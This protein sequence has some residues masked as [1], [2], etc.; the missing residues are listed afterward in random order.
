MNRLKLEQKNNMKNQ[1]SRNPVPV[2]SRQ[3][4]TILTGL[5]LAG[6]A[7]AQFPGG[8]GG[9]RTSTASTGA[10]VQQAAQQVTV[11]ADEYSNSL[12]ILAPDLVQTNIANLVKQLDV[13]V[14]DVTE[15]RVFTLQNADPTEMASVINDLFKDQTSSSS[16]NNSR[17][18]GFQFGG[19]GGNNGG[20]SNTSERSKLQSKVVAVADPR[21][22]SVL[23]TAS[24]DLMEQVA[25]M[26]AQLDASTSK[27]KK[28]FVYS[29]ENAQS[30]DVES[31]LRNLFE[32][33][34][35]RNGRTTSQNSQQNNALQ[36]RQTNASR[37]QGNTT[38]TSRV[39]NSTGQGGTTGR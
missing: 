25:P 30:E 21:T 26:I 34:N 13:A 1:F 33:Q 38:T 20:N 7:Q 9:G 35:T 18:P 27:K 16:G 8:N 36:Q 39:G 23:I 24:K 14:Q 15:L 4:L 5:A 31:V 28:V 32:T 29:L 10:S 37:T 12:I 2:G 6:T 22:S 11:V 3:F 17:G 19:R